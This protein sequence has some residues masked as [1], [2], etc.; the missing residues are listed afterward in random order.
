MKYE[1]IISE[2]KKKIYHPVYFLY[3]K[4]TYYI[5]L[6]ADYIADNTLLPE[7]QAFN[8]FIFY[9]KDSD[10]Q[11]IIGQAKKYPMMSNYQVIIVREAQTLK[12]LTTAPTKNK[13]N[14]FL[15]YCKNPLPSTILVFCYKQPFDSNEKFSVAFSN[16]LGSKSVIFESKQ[17]YERD[18]AGFIQQYVRSK[19]FSITPTASMLLIES[20]GMYLS[21]MVRELEKLFI[22]LPAGKTEITEKLVEQ[23]IGISREY[24]IFELQNKIAEGNTVQSFKIAHFLAARQSDRTI[25]MIE[26]L[27]DFFTKVLKYHIS[28]NK[29]N[30][31]ELATEIGVNKFFLKNYSMASKRFTVNKIVMVTGLLREYDMKCKGVGTSDDKGELFKELVAKI[32]YV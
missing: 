32:M 5:D 6:I 21:T 24:S 14:P 22:A 30:D 23:N 27:F 4:E 7:E 12:G 28:P 1:E 9:G 20:I 16:G 17:L 10:L 19:N 8:Q 18:I 31:Q 11:Q 25:F 13:A 26:R 15:L 2:L 29:G 3:G